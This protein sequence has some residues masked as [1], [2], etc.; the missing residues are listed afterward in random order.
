MF[1]LFTYKTPPKFSAE[2][3][4]Y[5]GFAN[6]KQVKVLSTT[7]LIIAGLTRV[8]GLLFYDDVQ[9]I[10]NYNAHSL[11]NWIQLSGSFIFFLTSRWAL[12]KP[13]ITSRMRQYITIAFIVFILLV[14]F[15]VSYTVSMYN[16][17]NTLT[18]F[19]IGIVVVS[20]F[21]A[22]EHKE[23]IMI[24]T[25]VIIIFIISMVIPRIDFEEKIMNVI[26][27]FVL[28][29][30]LMCASRYSYYF[31]SQHFVQVKQLEEKNLEI[32]RLNIQKSEILSFVAHDLRNPL[33]NIGTLSS[34]ILQENEESL[35]AKMIA[36]STKQA[37]EIINDLIDA[38][39][40]EEAILQT[41][42]TNIANYVEAIADKWRRN[43]N[44][45]IL[46][47]AIEIDVMAA[48]NY[49]K[50]ERVMDNIISNGLKFSDI[51]TPLSISVGRR[52]TN[53]CIVIK[54]YGIG[55][56]D[57]LLKY[58]FNQFTQAG[59][60]GLKGEKSV[61]LGLHISKKIV[62]QHKGR[63]IFSSIENQGSTFTILLPSA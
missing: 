21:F 48:I 47:E 7:L 51:D 54:D 5:Y 13:E 40:H 50:L 36:D 31:K 18:M 38:V 55:I 4:E 58:I 29:F 61:G 43:S 59:R 34:F 46:F 26:A 22:I 60:R 53:I 44:R 1:A 15:G 3:K 11:G 23:I 33:N 63:L 52:N 35:E 12:Q 20:L 28:A 19:L 14:S 32:E 25:S 62:E 41:E 49:S 24:S 37:K 10:R 6:L 39:K 27:S 42:P 57:K 8:L 2:F 16:T 45:N 56:P 30:I 17:K 9:N